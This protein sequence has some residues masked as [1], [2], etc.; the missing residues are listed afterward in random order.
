M[1]ATKS[2]IEPLPMYDGP[3]EAFHLDEVAKIAKKKPVDNWIRT[4]LRRR[5]PD[6]GRRARGRH[7]QHRRGR[8]AVPRCEE[9]PAAGHDVE[10]RPRQ[11][12]THPPRGPAVSRP[13]G[14]SLKRWADAERNAEPQR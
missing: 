4:H 12:G 2:G 14:R 3:T 1:S 6:L 10:P 8:A 9:R 11:A 13:T 7:R 5:P